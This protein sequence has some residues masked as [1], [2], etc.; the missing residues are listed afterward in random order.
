M[1]KLHVLILSFFLTSSLF[2]QNFQVQYP[3]GRLEVGPNVDPSRFNENVQYWKISCTYTDGSVGNGLL[4]EDTYEK[5]MRSKNNTT[6]D[7]KTHNAFF[8]LDNQIIWGT[9]TA[10]LEESSEKHPHLLAQ[11]MS[12]ALTTAPNILMKLGRLL[13]FSAQN[14]SIRSNPFTQNILLQNN[15]FADIGSR[16]AD[17]TSLLEQAKELSHA[18]DDR[19]A[20]SLNRKIDFV[21]NQLNKVMDAH[22][23]YEDSLSNN[24]QEITQEKILFKDSR[25]IFILKNNELS[26]YRVE[27]GNITSKKANY[28]LIHNIYLE[29]LDESSF[30]VYSANDSSTHFTFHDL[31][32]VKRRFIEEGVVY[33]AP[34]QKNLPSIDSSPRRAPLAGITDKRTYTVLSHSIERPEPNEYPKPPVPAVPS[35]DENKRYTPP[36]RSGGGWASSAR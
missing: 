4:I 2:A 28:G 3:S 8:K 18:F 7:N 10:V 23:K 22:E 1:Q 21:E 12:D 29:D 13:N 15:P 30:R 9:P 17:Y 19:I 36:A 24:P 35:K 6:R 32:H 27:N 34:A 5:L 20:S 25:S 33:K 11:D 14:P 31:N 16:V 26:L